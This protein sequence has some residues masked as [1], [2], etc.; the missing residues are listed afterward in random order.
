MKPDKDTPRGAFNLLSWRVNAVVVVALVAVSLAA[1]I[2][3]TEQANSIRGMVMGLGQIG[4]RDPGNMGAVAF[5]AMWV[6]MMAAMML[7]TI[8][9]MVLAHHAVAHRRLEG[10]LSTLAFVAGYLLV[11][12]AIGLVVF[13]AYSV[14]AQWRDDATQSHW[15][16]TLAGE[17]LVFA[18]AYQFMRWKRVCADIV[19]K[20]AGV[21]LHIRF[22]AWPAQGPAR[23][24]DLRRLLPRLLLGGDDR[25]GGRR[26]DEPC[27]D[28]D[29]VRAVL[30]RKE[31]EA[32]QRSG[33]GRRNRADA[34]RRRGSCL[35]SAACRHFQSGLNLTPG[36]GRAH[37]PG[38]FALGKK[39]CL[40]SIW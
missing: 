10:A 9:P 20:S 32:R 4:Y 27:L 30:P 2:S 25:A 18:G 14:Y 23:R 31:L 7:P 15:L 33:E 34:A 26:S 40:P 37:A 5:L 38:W 29:S 22:P 17:T 13:L 24:H 6:T 28:D 35:S 36:G 19:P 11:W 16:L 1:S 8:A 21:R 39:S 3:S 12:S